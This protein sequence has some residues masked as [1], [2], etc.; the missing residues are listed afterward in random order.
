MMDAYDIRANDETERICLDHLD[1]GLIAAAKR[2][3]AD[4]SVWSAWRTA[5]SKLPPEV[6]LDATTPFPFMELFPPRP[7]TAIR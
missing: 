4:G 3:A 5:A 2:I 6:F 7:V 1:D